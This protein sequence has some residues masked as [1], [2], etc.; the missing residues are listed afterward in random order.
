MDNWTNF[1][2]RGTVGE[3]A[4]AKD[5]IL[6]GYSV[7][8]ELGDNSRVDLIAIVNNH[9]VKIQVKTSLGE[10]DVASFDVVKKT[11]GYKYKYSVDDVDIFA[12]YVMK[13]DQV[14]YVSSEEALNQK[15]YISFKLGDPGRVNQFKQRFAKDY[16]DLSEALASSGIGV[17]IG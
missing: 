1:K 6:Q 4:V 12:L 5:L 2:P 8:T 17:D 13:T 15:S 16:L 11:F 9:P 7:F 3:L 10:N 14:L